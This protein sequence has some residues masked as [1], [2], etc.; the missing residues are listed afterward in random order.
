MSDTPGPS[1]ST[2]TAGTFPEGVKLTHHDYCDID[3]KVCIICQKRD[4]RSRVSSTPNG[5][6]KIKHAGEIR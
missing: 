1:S 6:D 2:S 4:K 5:R 3:L